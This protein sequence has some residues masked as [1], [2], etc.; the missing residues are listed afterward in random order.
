MIGILLASA[1][2]LTPGCDLEHPSGEGAC[3][4]AQVDRLPINRLQVVGSHNSYK[5]AIA[6]AEMALVRAVQPKLAATLDYA[7][8]PL[9]SELDKGARQLELDI[10]NDPKGGLFATP[11]AQKLAG[12]AA[13]APYDASQMGV[14]GF[15]VLHVQ[16]ID[17][18]SSCARFVQC[19]TDI[20]TWS[21]AHSDH[22]P[23]LILLNLKDDNL[24]GLPGTVSILPFDAQAMDAIDAEIRSVFPARALITPGSVQKGGRLAWPRLKAA[25][26]K[27]MFALDESPEKVALYRGRRHRLEGRVMFV[28][29]DPGSPAAGYITLNEPVAD[30]RAISRALA[31][32]VIVRTRADADTAEARANDGRRREAALASGA[33]YVSTD[34]LT[35]DLRFGPYHVGLPGGLVARANPVVK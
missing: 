15:K 16:D 26:G 24:K 21:K 20:R 13:S 4:R 22:V 3:S 18:R 2:V 35:P 33:Q 31:R 6:P 9:A 27:V 11:L 1:L 30:A 28:N 5:Q 32:G 7:H 10:L 12:D 14:P 23:I 19:L 8:A 25:R 29:T 17:Y 34:Y